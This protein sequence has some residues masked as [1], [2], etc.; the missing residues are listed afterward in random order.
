ME[1]FRV[2]L[3]IDLCR[4]E[5]KNIQ[6]YFDD[7]HGILLSVGQVVAWAIN[8]I[9]SE[10]PIL[11]MKKAYSRK[12]IANQKCVYVTVRAKFYEKWEAIRGHYS[13]YHGLDPSMALLSIIYQMSAAI[14][15]N[16]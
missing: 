11:A 9:D 6:D 12:I 8:N 4:K 2:P 14:S 1:K 7:R 5:I 13:V 15:A 16:K 3:Q 10:V